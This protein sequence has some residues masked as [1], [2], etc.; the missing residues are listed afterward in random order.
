MKSMVKLAITLLNEMGEATGI[1]TAAD[2]KVVVSRCQSEGLSFLT[3]T[4]PAMEKE[5][6]FHLHEQGYD[7]SIAFA[8]FGKRDGTPEFL[9][10]FLSI[11][12]DENG[13]YR[14]PVVPEDWD[15][16]A[17]IISVL[18]QFLLLASKVNMECTQ[19][20]VDRA[21]RSYIDTDR[22]LLT[23][24]E[25][26]LRSFTAM[27]TK[28]LGPFLSDVE[29]KL[30]KSFTPSFSSGALATRETY[31]ERFSSRVWTERLEEIFPHSYDLVVNYRDQLS[32]E[33][34]ILDRACETPS[35]VVHVPKTMKTPRIIAEEPV[36]NAYAQQGIL[37]Q[38]NRSLEKFPLLVE[39][40]GW[41]YQEYNRLLA[42]IGSETGKLATI[43]LSDA[44]DRVS[45][46]LVFGGLL[47]NHHFL[48]QAISA[49][50]SER[51]DVYG[52]VISLNKFA[53][54]GSA[55]T[56]PIETMVFYVIICLA[57][58]RVYGS[59]TSTLTPVRNGVRVYGDDIIVPTS[60]VPTLT[61]LLQAYGLKVN[62][63]KSFYKGFF[64][65]SCGEDWYAGR[66]VSPVRLRA[67]LPCD[68]NDAKGIVRAIEFHNHLFN[69]GWYETAEFVAL[70]LISL[71][72]IPRGSPSTPGLHLHS[73]FEQD[74]RI[75]YNRNL[76]RTELYTLLVREV[77]PAD[78]L[79]GYGA[80][81]KF[82]RSRFEDR[83]ADH[84]LRD[85]RSQCA[86]INTGW[87]PLV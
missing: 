3:I 30:F 32:E 56:F 20:R 49:C 68:R 28:V 83:E 17:Q 78:P 39:G 35:K 66:S 16:Q 18:R 82:F 53:S 4:L 57:W 79:D 81:R 1:S 51:A 87:V 63:N 60:L 14:Q 85:G 76:Q 84:L 24:P 67:P 29:N 70:S 41:K 77:K 46:Q 62:T 61:G 59:L 7:S 71:R 80:L 54:M 72:F 33:V 58:E 65:E 74:W 25:S 36:Y 8:G 44:S 19:E 45:A 6:M 52:E 86:G 31:N 13:Q 48:S 34:H 47:K 9:G 73:F 43:D 11:L 55:L 40:L 15:Y 10:G 27:S 42:Q 22:D 69:K 38:M 5:L 75:R 23:I 50:R 21:M 26:L 2:E 64:R 12:F 37:K